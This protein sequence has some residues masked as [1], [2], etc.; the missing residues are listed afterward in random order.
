[1]K[2][3][4]SSVEIFNHKK[5]ERKEVLC[6]NRRV[7]KQKRGRGKGKTVEVEPWVK[8][9]K[10]NLGKCPELLEPRKGD[11]LLFHCETRQSV[12]PVIG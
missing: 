8:M 12:I 9:G 6:S 4:G 10:A 1:M 5:W 2:A 7:Q 11:G 3:L